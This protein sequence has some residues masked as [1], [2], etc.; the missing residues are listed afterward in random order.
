MFDTII[1]MEFNE[2]NRLLSPV[3]FKW[4]QKKWVPCVCPG[5]NPSKEYRLTNQIKYSINN[6]YCN[7]YIVNKVHDRRIGEWHQSLSRPIPF[8]SEHIP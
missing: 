5:S 4:I 3:Y 1:C 2:K 6:L 8:G 7:Q